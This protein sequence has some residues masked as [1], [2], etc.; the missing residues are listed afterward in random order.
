MCC[1]LCKSPLKYL[2]IYVGNMQQL[3]N[4]VD[5]SLQI[6]ALFKVATYVIPKHEEMPFPQRR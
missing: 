4:M 5:I 6:R 2:L 1:F 3:P